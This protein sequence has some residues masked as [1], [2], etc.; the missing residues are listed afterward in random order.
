MA[1]PYVSEI[2]MFGFNFAPRGWSLCD[3]QILPTNQNQT[4]FSLIGTAF[5]GDG[6]TTFGLPDLRGRTPIHP[7]TDPYGFHYERGQKG[8]AE[9][10]TLTQANMPTHTHV[11]S[12]ATDVAD[13][14]PAYQ[15]AYFSVS[16]DTKGVG[17]GDSYRA[18]TNL[19]D[20]NPGFVSSVGG[21][22]SHNNMQ[23]Y[24][25]V[26]FAIAMTGVFPSRN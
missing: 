20:M 11:V 12:A 15:D 22:Q 17:T 10:V 3:G 23:P 13:P 26:S 14:L 4:L 16:S 2:R 1:D 24:L 6:R 9:N 18:A 5:G 21:N 8:G 19:V 25:A 7:G